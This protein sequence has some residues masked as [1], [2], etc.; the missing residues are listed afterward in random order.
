MRKGTQV[1][2]L[3]PSTASG[4]WQSPA[5]EVLCGRQKDRIATMAP[6]PPTLRKITEPK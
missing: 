3:A 5:G 6:G 1:W 4:R 2:G